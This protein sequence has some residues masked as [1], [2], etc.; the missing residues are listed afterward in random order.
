MRTDNCAKCRVNVVTTLHKNDA[1]VN[2]CFLAFCCCLFLTF[3][4][5][6]PF[7]TFLPSLSLINCSL[8]IPAFP[9]AP[10]LNFSLCFFLTPVASCAA[11]K[12]TQLIIRHFIWQP[13]NYVCTQ[14]PIHLKVRRKRKKKRKK[15]GTKRGRERDGGK[16][17]SR[18]EHRTSFCGA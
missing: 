1:S 4:P 14:S 2:E 12:I 7:S 13:A 10:K 11:Q 17:T 15:R 8:Y 16:G 9:S 18:T 6:S 3:F 5:G